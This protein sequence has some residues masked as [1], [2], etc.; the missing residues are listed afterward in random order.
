MTTFSYD[1]H[2]A[3]TFPTLATA[4][5]LAEGIPDPLD[6]AEDVAR[7]EAEALRELDGRTEADLPAI[8]AWR[9]A[10]ATMGHKPTQ[11]RCASEALL[12]RL[13]KS[14]SLPRVSPLVDLCN[15][16]SAAHAVPV[17]AFDLDRI[18]GDLTVRPAAGTETYLTFGGET[19]TPVPGE[20]VFA[21][22]AGIAHARRWTNRQSAASAVSPATRRALI[23][24]EALHDAS[25][26]D[27][28]A[29]RD[30]VAEALTA[31]G[32]T[33]RAGLIRGGVGAFDAGVAP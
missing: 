15:A 11:V 7:L 5:A 6:A 12:R 31:L 1:P 13:R 32:A 29:A 3:R 25:E 16:A 22:A 10:F 18:T 28:T 33:V 21:D 24:I 19:E 20:I 26:A 2:I 4:L 27:A 14:G 30:A 8:R 9:A 23:V 17:A